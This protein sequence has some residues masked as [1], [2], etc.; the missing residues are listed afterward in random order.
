MT[1]SRTRPVL[2]IFLGVPPG[3]CLLLVALF[4]SDGLGAFLQVQG[5]SGAGDIFFLLVDIFCSNG[6]KFLLWYAHQASVNEAPGLPLTICVMGELVKN[7]EL[8]CEVAA[9][10]FKGPALDPSTE[11]KDAE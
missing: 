4:P 8:G 1:W 3:V 10:G 6:Q 11:G 5:E 7:N 9:K 2:G